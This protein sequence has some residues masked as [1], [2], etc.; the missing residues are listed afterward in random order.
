MI[1]IKH[2]PGPWFVDFD[3]VRAPEHVEGGVRIYSTDWEI[4]YVR[5]HTGDQPEGDADQTGNRGQRPPDRRRA[6]STD[7][8]QRSLPSIL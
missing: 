3:K 7:G 6:G 8:V 4:A 1:Q 5:A 2:T